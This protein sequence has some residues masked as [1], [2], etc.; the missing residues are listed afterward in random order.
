[1]SRVDPARLEDLGDVLTEVRSWS[2]VEDRGGGTFYV[3]RKPFL[4][5]HVGPD[6]RRADVKAAGGWIEIDLPAPAP[7]VAR[8][9]FLA[10]LRDEYADR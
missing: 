1:M 6:R 3:H 10:L 4:H 7:A 2:G 9:R 5:F 8:R